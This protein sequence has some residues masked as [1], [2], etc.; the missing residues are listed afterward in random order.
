MN[1]VRLKNKFLQTLICSVFVLGLVLTFAPQA[2]SGPDEITWNVALWGGER[3]WTR[4]L[5][6]W[7]A[8][9]EKMTNGRW[10][11]KLHYGAVLSPSKEHLD[12]L[13]AGLFEIQDQLGVYVCGGKRESRKTPEEITAYGISRQFS[14]ASELIYASKMAAKVDS[15]LIQDNYQIY[16]H[17]FLFTKSGNWVVVQ[18]GMNIQNQTARRYH[19]LSSAVKDFIERPHSGI[20]SGAKVKPLNLTS[21][22]SDSNREASLVAFYNSPLVEFNIQKITPVNKYHIRRFFE[23]FFQFFNN[24]QDSP[25]HYKAAGLADV[26]PVYIP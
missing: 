12:G 20:I 1:R 2:I 9:M 24:S 17:N 15:S 13:K 6:R 25:S 4:P 16:Q 21:E 23:F 5:H 22:K 18:Q 26:I 8:D 10:K 11:I 7:A 19:W 3:D 14:F